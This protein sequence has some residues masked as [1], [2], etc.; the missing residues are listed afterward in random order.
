MTTARILAHYESLATLSGRM[1]E[2]AR[3]GEWDQLIDLERQRTEIVAAV[4]PLDAAQP[5]D[6]TARERK[7]A[8]ITAALADEAEVRTLVQAWMSEYEHTQQCNAQELRLLR[9]YGC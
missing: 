6:A 1:A 8:L 3:L 9:E 4:Q 7:N 5:L 2:A